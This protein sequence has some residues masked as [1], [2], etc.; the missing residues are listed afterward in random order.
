[1]QS[2]KQYYYSYTSPST[3]SA[4]ANETAI[5]PPSYDEAISTEGITTPSKQPLE[6]YIA[7][8]GTLLETR[9]S[10]DTDFL[11]GPSSRQDSPP[12]YSVYQA[13]FRS[14][15]DG[16]LSR[17]DHLN[18]DG[19]ALLQFLHQHNTPPGMY[20]QFYGY[21]E[22]THWRRRVSQD[23][24]GN[25]TEEMEPVTQRV[26]D[27]TFQMECSQYVVPVCQGLLLRPD[28]QGVSKSVRE[29]CDDY[30]HEDR[31]LKELQLTKEIQW[32]YAELTRGLTAAIRGCGYINTLEISYKMKNHKVIVKAGSWVSYMSDHWL[33]RGFFYLTCLWIIAWPILWMT[34]KK[35]GHTDLKSEWTMCMSERIWYE[36]HI[37]EVL[38]QVRHTN[39]FTVPF[40]L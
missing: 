29:L 24:D 7:D 6:G 11:L 35:F 22:E 3:S 21:H 5:R 4:S 20:I 39:P 23:S 32:N 2:N 9:D 12:G 30:V 31:Q 15:E 16:V 1:M 36:Q 40:I 8:T 18:R 19:E 33:V 34:R 25:R 14:S 37:Q 17:D 26:D 28:A 38:S 10:L 27:F 13:T